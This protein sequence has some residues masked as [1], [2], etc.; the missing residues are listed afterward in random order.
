MKQHSELTYIAVGS[1]RFGGLKHRLFL[2]LYER[3]QISISDAMLFGIYQGLS[4]FLI[5]LGS[6]R[7][8]VTRNNIDHAIKYRIKI[9]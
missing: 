8:A 5:T 9:K 6:K 4:H 3:E 2:Q 1:V 7:F